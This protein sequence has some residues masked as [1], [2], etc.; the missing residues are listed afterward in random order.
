MVTGTRMAAGEREKSSHE[1]CLQM[2]VG[3]IRLMTAIN[4]GYEEKS[5][6]ISLS[7]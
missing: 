6:E 3:P 1:G 7:N 2:Q 5:P 4:V